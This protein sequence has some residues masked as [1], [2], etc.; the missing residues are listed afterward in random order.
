MKF[1]IRHAI[2]AGLVLFFAALATIGVWA[3]YLNQQISERLAKGWFLPPTEIHSDRMRIY[4]DTEFKPELFIDQLRALGF[5]ATSQGEILRALEYSQWDQSFC[6]QNL[7]EELPLETTSCFVFITEPSDNTR[8]LNLIALGADRRVQALYQGEPPL[9]VQEVSLKPFL[10]AQ[11]YGGEP[12][13]RDLTSL[14][15][16]PLVCLQAVTAIEDSD[17]LEHAGVSITGTLRALARN[18]T[19]GRYAQGGSTITQ[20]LV[21]NF[22][23]TPEKTIKR[24]VTEQI[25]AF[26]VESRFSKDEILE[27]YLNI[28]Y[29]GQ[30]GP[31]QLRGYGSASKHYF[32]KPISSLN[33]SECALLASL[34]N[35]PGRYNPFNHPERATARRSLVL[36]KMLELEMIST[37]DA[38]T[39]KNKELPPKPKRILTEPAPYYVQAVLKQIE[40]LE[41][42]P[43]DGLKIYT[44]LNPTA[45]EIGQ[46]H[47]S[48]EVQRLETDFKKLSE[49]KASGKNLQAALLSVDLRSN[50]IIAM[51]GGRGFKSTQ[52]NRAR[53]SRRQ[54][55]SIMKPFV[56]LTALESLTPEGE[57]YSP[58]T[59]ISDEKLNY[60]YE[61]QQWSPSNYDNKT[62]GTVPLF[63][64][65]K[66]SLNIATARLG[67]DV[68]L[69]AIVDLAKRLGV[70]SEVK[71]LPSLSLGAF[72]L[73]VWEVAR[74]YAALAHMGEY[75]EIRMIQRV[76]NSKGELLWQAEDEF[77]TV[78]TPQAVAKLVGMMK[79]T[80]KNGT[81]RSTQWR[82]F[83]RPAAGKTG[84]TS[85]TKD[86]WFAGFTPYILTVV[87]VG[88]DDN[89]H[90]G[91]TGSSGAVPLWT[92]YMKDF[93]S[94]LPADDFEWPEGVE[95]RELSVSDLSEL[96]EGVE[97]MEP[98]TEPIELIY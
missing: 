69:S 35:S 61:G 5:K 16:I 29:M 95:I 19:S 82:G 88:Y 9:R 72:E 55:G 96:Y 20:Q 64:G 81:A 30:N 54:V 89:T 44:Y 47:L 40:E 1:T 26:L 80:L 67:I 75:K 10:F 94:T 51:I 13:L 43:S 31:F 70:E 3:L 77:K 76:E 6:Q 14:G 53:D 11:Y 46:T 74:A 41:I 39:S 38:N 50:G 7:Q 68:G 87:W 2:I 34:V 37:E 12:I 71:A 97:N 49:L 83:T 59:M 17:F 86:A 32:N 79:Q 15:G 66:E 42:D 78:A 23:L 36:D 63:V 21:K 93:A 58:L 60:R 92:Q 52:Y 73:S 18:I 65:L 22:F 27:N 33:L 57:D 45:Q 28:I 56:Y 4:E 25:M 48:N 91:L 98:P 90:H 62:H 84:T 85:D 24:K 8:L